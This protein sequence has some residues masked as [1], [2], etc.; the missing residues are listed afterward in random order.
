MGQPLVTP[1]QEYEVHAAVVFEGLVFVLVVND[2]GYP[3]WRTTWLF[4]VVDSAVPADWICST[5]HDDPSLIFGPEFIAGSPEGY[6]A[7]VE[8]EPEQ[9]ARFWKRAEERRQEES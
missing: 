5:F 8:L 2:L 9:V 3:T 7:M 6:A 1:G 4:D